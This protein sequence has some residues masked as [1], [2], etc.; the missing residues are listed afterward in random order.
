MNRIA[1]PCR[2]ICRQ[3]PDAG[4]CVGCGRTVREVFLWFDMTEEARAGV[5]EALPAR[6][7]SLPPERCG[8]GD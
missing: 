4:F 8:A 6:L 7:A 3:D 1:T 5:V 2:R